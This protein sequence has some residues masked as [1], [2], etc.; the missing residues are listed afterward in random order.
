MTKIV[1][2]VV[3]LIGAIVSAEAN[4]ITPVSQAMPSLEIQ[5]VSLH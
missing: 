1:S 2:A 3:L 5:C 4:A